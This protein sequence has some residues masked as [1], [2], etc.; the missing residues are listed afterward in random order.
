MYILTEYIL[1]RKGNYSAIK[2]SSTALTWWCRSLLLWLGVH[3]GL[4]RSVRWLVLLQM[5]WP[6]N[7]YKALR[8]LSFNHSQLFIDFFLCVYLSK[9]FR[10]ISLSLW[11]PCDCLC[12]T[13]LPWR[14]GFKYNKHQAMKMNHKPFIMIPCSGSLSNCLT[15][16][17]NLHNRICTYFM[18]TPPKLFSLTLFSA[19]IAMYMHI[20]TYKVF[21]GCKAMS[22]TPK[23]SMGPISTYHWMVLPGSESRD[24]K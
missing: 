12:A 6:W 16:G 10:V 17:I 18:I 3:I 20:S 1:P 21:F 23:I 2:G 15:L 14:T 7:M 5:Y 11:Y 8:H 24:P 22:F 9:S 19:V 4:K 13:G